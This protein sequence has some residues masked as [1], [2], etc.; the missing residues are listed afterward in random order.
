MNDEWM[1][2]QERK[3]EKN[4]DEEVVLRDRETESAQPDT[5]LQRT[6]ITRR[7]RLALRLGRMQ[8]KREE[9]DN[10]NDERKEEKVLKEEERKN[11]SRMSM[12]RTET[13]I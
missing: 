7:V 13:E 12:R 9:T 1:R 11:H 3:R 10:N 2:E 4:T 8:E 6:Q 5:V